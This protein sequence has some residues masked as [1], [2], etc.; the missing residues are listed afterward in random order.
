MAASKERGVS[1]RLSVQPQWLDLVFVG[2]PEVNG[3]NYIIVP[4]NVISHTVYTDTNFLLWTE[5]ER[6]STQ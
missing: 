4:I 6:N 3:S 5:C 1:F 2:G